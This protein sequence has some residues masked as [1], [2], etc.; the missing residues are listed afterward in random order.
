MSWYVTRSE[1]GRDRMV[2]TTESSLEDRKSVRWKRLVLGYRSS[3][4]SGA[5]IAEPKRS[6]SD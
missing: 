6:G 2:E 5:K 3:S 4:R 1:G